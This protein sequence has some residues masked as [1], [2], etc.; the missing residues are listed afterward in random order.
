MR[1]NHDYEIDGCLES[2]LEELLKP[3]QVLLISTWTRNQC[4]VYKL[5]IKTVFL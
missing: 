5:N 1:Y 3:P 2:K 4:I